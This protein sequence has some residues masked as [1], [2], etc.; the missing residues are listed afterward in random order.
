MPNF[1][2]HPLVVLFVGAI[3]TGLLIPW[4]TRQWQNRQKELELKTEIVSGISES[5]V[6]LLT[7]VGAVR[8]LRTWLPQ[9]A[10]DDKA[11]PRAEKI[12]RRYDEAWDVMN[13][14]YHEYEVKSAVILTKLKAYLP[15]TEIPSKWVDFS[16]I[17]KGFYALE[18]I[19]DV[20][21]HRQFKDELREKLS[22][23]L[24]L[25]SMVGEDWNEM[26]NKILTAQDELI[27]KILKS[28]IPLI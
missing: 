2:S 9:N 26:F 14:A 10:P 1:L 8:V 19:H 24:N 16:Y 22:G 7:C 6:N 20:Q 13:R 4:L 25:E 11:P 17:V 5:T 15:E 3:I 21:K 18:G 27:E 28:R 12:R 23:L